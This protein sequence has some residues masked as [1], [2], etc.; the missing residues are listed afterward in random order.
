M[1]KKYLW[2]FCLSLNIKTLN[3]KTN[4][5]IFLF[6]E[7]L[8]LLKGKL[9]GNELYEDDVYLNEENEDYVGEENFKPIMQKK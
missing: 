6:K 9:P 8:N 3:I 4:S 7:T 2:V 5:Y 1:R